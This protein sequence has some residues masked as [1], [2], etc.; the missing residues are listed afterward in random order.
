MSTQS[1]DNWECGSLSVRLFLI[2]QR[3]TDARKLN[4]SWAHAGLWVDFDSSSVTANQDLCVGLQWNILS[5]LSHAG[6]RGIVANARYNRRLYPLSLEAS[7]LELCPATSG[8]EDLY[9]LTWLSHSHTHTQGGRKKHIVI[10]SHR[11]KV[12]S[13][14]SARM[15]GQKSTQ[16]KSGQISAG[17]HTVLQSVMKQ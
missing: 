9:L 17:S 7:R 16:L 15:S 1:G 12:V 14:I 4:L 8:S 3:S 11:T 2:M 5:E 13:L 6:D 10:I